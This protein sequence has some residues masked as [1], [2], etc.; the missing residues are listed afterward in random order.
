V[1][2]L[3]SRQIKWS[4]HLD[5]TTQEAS[6]KAFIYSCARQC[7][8]A[9]VAGVARAGVGGWGG[10]GLDGSSPAPASIALYSATPALRQQQSQNRLF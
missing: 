3:H 6:Y 8:G 7:G 10:W 1:F 2:D 4:Q 9:G 5:L